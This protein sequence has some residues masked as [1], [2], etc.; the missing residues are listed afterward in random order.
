M[1]YAFRTPNGIGSAG[2]ASGGSLTLNKPSAVA[3][4]DLLVVTAYLESDTN[5]WTTIPSGWNTSAA[6]TIVNTGAFFVQVFW[7]IAASEGASW[8]WVPTTNAWRTLS[9]ASY[10]GGTGSGERV[11]VSAKAQADTALA[12]AQTAPTI[13]TT[14]NDDLVTFN[15]GNFSGTD[16][17]GTQVGFCTN[18]RVTLGGVDVADALKA[19]AGATGTSAPNSGIGSQTYAA[20]HVGFLLAPGGAAA[21]I[22][23]VLM[24]EYRQRG[25]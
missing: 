4:G 6:L 25:Q 13:T 22:V 1:A 21:S 12:G 3:D 14:V 17:A 11:D 9:I 23:P 8:A 5:T 24:A 15:Y 20:V 7:K 19:V 2:N 16:P 18:L 10:T